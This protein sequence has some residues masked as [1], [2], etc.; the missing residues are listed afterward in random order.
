MKRLLWLAPVAAIG[1][2]AAWFLLRSEGPPRVPFVMVER[3]SLAGIVSTNGKI[4]PLEWADVRA[5]REGSI[6]R[7]LV[8]KGQRVEKGAS[9]AE[10]DTRQA[11]IDLAAAEARLT[12]VRAEL[13]VVEHGGRASELAEI[14]GSLARARLDLASA[15]KEVAALERLA[16]K[17]AATRQQVVDATAAVDRLR[18]QIQSL[19]RKRASLV[20]GTDR[21]VAQARVAESQTAVEAARRRIDLANL[22]TPIAGVIFDVAVRAGAYVNPGDLVAKTGRLDKLRALVYVDEP[23]LGRV[24]PGMPVDITWDA[25]PGRTWKASVDKV[26]TQV[27]PLGTRQVGEVVCL[28]DNPHNE[29]LPGTNINAEIRTQQADNVLSIPREAVRRDERGAGLYVLDGTRV[30]WRN[31][32]LGVS[33]ATHIEVKRGV[34]EGERIAMPTEVALRDGIEI[35]PVLPKQD[36]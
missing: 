24:A 9:I 20:G 7:V 31:T 27:A 23:D 21:V 11:R 35:E 18:T 34:N 10:L 5:S 2:G 22:R 14:D 32:E 4:E 8:E 19:E 3:R 1:A 36:Q 33:S 13:E 28:L 12:Q 25:L 15:Q 29:L 6:E 16:A 26:P 17:Q 30:R